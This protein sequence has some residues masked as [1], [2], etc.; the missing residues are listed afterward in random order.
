MKRFEIIDKLCFE[1]EGSP[2]PLE[3]LYTLEGL[4]YVELIK[5]LR[6]S[7]KGERVPEWEELKGAERRD[8]AKALGADDDAELA[9]RAA[10]GFD[11]VSLAA[12]R[13]GVK[14]KPVPN[15][16]AELIQMT[17]AVAI[18]MACSGN[19]HKGAATIVTVAEELLAEI[20]KRIAGKAEV[21]V[22]ADTSTDDDLY[23]DD[24]W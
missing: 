14:I 11:A 6:A 21:H 15:N 19:V 8:M 22:P 17:S 9:R 24:D 18:G 16:R 12:R 5:I 7:E 23:T 20:D 4:R 1:G 3:A 2:Y 13:S 10:A